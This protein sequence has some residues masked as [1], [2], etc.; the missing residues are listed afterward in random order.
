MDVDCSDL[1]SG[2][3]EKE[4][5][6]QTEKI[7]KKVSGIFLFQQ[8]YTYMKLNLNLFFYNL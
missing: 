2:K 3:E 1:D 7:V 4:I 5:E 8:S 6:T